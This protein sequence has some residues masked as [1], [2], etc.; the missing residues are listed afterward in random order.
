MESKQE[1]LIL[2]EQLEDDFEEAANLTQ[3]TVI[4]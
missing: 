2:E 4:L 1:D 3:E